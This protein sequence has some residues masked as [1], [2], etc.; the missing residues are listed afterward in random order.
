[1]SSRRIIIRYVVRPLTFRPNFTLSVE[2]ATETANAGVGTS[3][4]GPGA[5]SITDEEDQ[6]KGEHAMRSLKYANILTILTF[7]ALQ[8]N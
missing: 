8:C 6:N 2:G 4:E 3:T 7:F 1:M 5:D